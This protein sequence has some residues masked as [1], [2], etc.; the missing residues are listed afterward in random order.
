MH[1]NTG[2][3]VN[4]HTRFYVCTEHWM[5][6]SSFIP[7]L[8]RCRMTFDEDIKCTLW[9]LFRVFWLFVCVC[10]VFLWWTR[11]NLDGTMLWLLLLFF[12][13][14]SVHYS[15]CVCVTFWLIVML[16][17]SLH[18]R[19]IFAPHSKRRRP[20]LLFFLSFSRPGSLR[21]ILSPGSLNCF[22]L[23]LA[24]IEL[25]SLNHKY[26]YTHKHTRT[27][28]NP[29]SNNNSGSK[30][31]RAEKK[32]THTHSHHLFVERAIEYLLRSLSLTEF[33][34]ATANLTAH[35][36]H[37]SRALICVAVLLRCCS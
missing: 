19:L 4:P 15:V 32:H 26:A 24:R 6:F 7:F 37:H 18:A 3:R 36:A 2:A 16:M 29:K 11:N 8:L 5:I 25:T 34:S 10:A 20:V 17:H 21:H 12:L 9:F 22:Q 31:W 28:Q 23:S 30:K 27:Q 35:T 1:T 13:H 14:H 33:L